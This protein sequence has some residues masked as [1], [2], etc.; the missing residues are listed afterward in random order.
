MSAVINADS[1]EYCL[2]MLSQ[3][4]PTPSPSELFNRIILEV[5]PGEI[6]IACKSMHKADLKL[7]KSI[8]LRAHLLCHTPFSFVS[9]LDQ[10]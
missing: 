10:R 6:E 2:R 9:I 4:V 1:I 7:G 5:S 3:S 8:E